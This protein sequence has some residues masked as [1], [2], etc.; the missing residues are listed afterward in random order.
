MGTTPLPTEEKPPSIMEPAA[1]KITVNETKA[2]FPPLADAPDVS[3]I[4]ADTAAKVVQQAQAPSQSGDNETT[5]W[6]F[7][8]SKGYSRNQVAGILGNLQQEHGFK[9]SE[10]PG[11][12]GIA[13]WLGNRADNLRAR[14][15]HLDITTQLQFLEDELNGPE[16]Q[17]K[18]ALA[19]STT[20][21][22]ATMAFSSLF[23]RCGD[24]RNEQ[25]I[26]YAYQILGRH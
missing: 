11:G 3:K 14:P 13:Q 20:V 21:E 18:A 1:P 26:S 12:L 17:A 15:N 9:T 4:A 24:C 5:A 7:F 2:K 6:N 16:G 8:V 10:A 22:Q 25:R 19:A 23:E